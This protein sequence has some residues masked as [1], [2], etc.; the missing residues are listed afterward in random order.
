MPKL[1]DEDAVFAATT[2]LLVEAGYDQATTQA[3]AARAGVHEATLFRRYGSK[4]ALV[5]RAVT[6]L[7]D[8]VPLARVTFTGDLEADLEAIVVAYLETSAGH[9][10]LVQGILLELSRRPELRPALDRPVKTIGGIVEI[11]GAYQARGQL[12]PEPPLQTLGAL[13]G[14]LLASESF[15]RAARDLA[16]PPVD[17]KAHVRGFLHGRAL[18]G[19]PS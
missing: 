3:I 13:L 4:A 14:P 10:A 5:A 16:V 19:A 2:A 17:P 18:P 7:L 9:G 6:R 1:I 8:Q 11:L 12:R 15:R